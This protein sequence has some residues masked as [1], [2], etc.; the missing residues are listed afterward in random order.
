M[1]FSSVFNCHASD[2]LHAYP[3]TEDYPHFVV[4]IWAFWCQ[5]VIGYYNKLGVNWATLTETK[6]NK[7]KRSWWLVIYRLVFYCLVFSPTSRISGLIKLISW[8]GCHIFTDGSPDTHINITYV[9]HLSSLTSDIIDIVQM[10]E[11]TYD[12]HKLYQYGCL[13]K[14]H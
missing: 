3:C 13:E 7:Y 5:C 12:G 6:M 10:S 9:R 8:P 1:F 14:R 2:M 11:M 4:I